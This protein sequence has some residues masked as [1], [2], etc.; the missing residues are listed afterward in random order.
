[1]TFIPNS[2]VLSH[3]HVLMHFVKYCTLEK[4]LPFINYVIFQ[5]RL[6]NKFL[7]KLD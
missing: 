6:K 4:A 2:F 3:Q 5:I 1:M 7:V